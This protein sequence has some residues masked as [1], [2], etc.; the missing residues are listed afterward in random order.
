[1][2]PTLLIID[3]EKTIR[4]SLSYLFKD[5][6]FDV[7]TAGTAAEGL[8]LAASLSPD[9]IILDY[10]LPDRSG[11]D[12]LLG[13]RAAM[14]DSMVIMLTAFG[15]IPTAVKA[16]HAGAFDYLTKPVDLETLELSADRACEI[17]RLRKE[18]QLLKE[19]QSAG[20]QDGMI[21]T[22]PQ[23]HKLQLMIN[24]LAENP[25]TTVLIEG[26][27]GTGKEVAARAVHNLSERR[28]RPFM[29]INCATLSENLIESELFGHERGAFTDAKTMK[30]GL[31]E[32]ADGGT[33]FLDEIGELS[34]RL[35]P[36]LLRVLETRT[37]R[38][39]GGTRDIK[40]DVRFIA[41]TNRRLQDAVNAK[42]FRED[43]YYRL[44][45][46]PLTIPP[47]RERGGDVVVLARYFI[48][49]SDAVLKKKI[50]GITPEAESHLM[51]YSWPGNIRELKN[52]IE[53]AVILSPGPLLTDE[54]LPRELTVAVSDRAEDDA[55][56]LEEMEKRHVLSV[57]NRH[58]G[59]QSQA[60]R[61]L[62][63]SRSTLISKLKKYGHLS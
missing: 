12:T 57:L 20:V 17:S 45:V 37:F 47:L 23:V 38:R 7:Y 25:A 54:H 8:G 21:G 53:R 24:L 56:S 35:Q 60:A 52:V 28:D 41:A 46:M 14:A 32:V 50:T 1:M 42:S 6:G 33:I 3:D 48:S 61:A 62:G 55:L 44:R 13:I 51:T 27:S 18:N 15:S 9:L 10:K 58:F 39:V 11:M 49:A 19:R 31:L 22:S 34:L 30:R 26:E 43:L 40:S 4:L 63:I 2:N 36:K 5:K 59:N 16:I 29:D